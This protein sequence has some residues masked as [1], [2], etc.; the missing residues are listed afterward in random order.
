MVTH[1]EFTPREELMYEVMNA[2][3]ESGIPISF[4]GAMVLR[5]ALR[6]PGSLMRS[7]ILKTLMRTGIQELLLHVS[8]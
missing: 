1:M 3:Y 4:K 6:K 5:H 8:R 7:V 2:I